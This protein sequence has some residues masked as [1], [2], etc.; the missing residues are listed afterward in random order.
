MNITRKIVSLMSFWLCTQVAFAQTVELSEG[1][2]CQ[3]SEVVGQD[4][5]ALSSGRA[6]SAKWYPTSVPTTVMGALTAN[7]EYQ[8]ILEKDN[9]RQYDKQRFLVPWLFKKSFRLDGLNDN[10]HVRLLFEGLDYRADI[11]LNGV[12][13]ASRDTIAGP[14]RT[15]AIDVTGV[16][17]EQN[18]LVVETWRCQPG[19]YNIGFVDWNPRPLDE[20]MGIVRPVKV[21][22]C[23]PVVIESPR[24]CTRLNL[25]TLKEAWVNVETQV[26]N[27]SNRDVTGKLVCS[28]EGEECDVPVTLKAK[29]TKTVRIDDEVMETLHVMNP[30]LWWCYTMGSPTLYSMNLSFEQNDVLSDNQEVSFGIREV[31]SFI[32]S[33]G[34]RAFT[35]N[36]K[37]IQLL[38]AGWTDDI[39]L[40][41][42]ADSYDRQLEMV[43]QMNLNTVRLEGFWGTSQALYDLCDEK[44]IL[45]L[46]GWSC[47]WEWED[48]LGK[49]C[50]DRY[51]G[52][53]TDD[54]VEIISRS[55]DDQLRYL[56]NHPSIIAW[57]VGSDKLPVPK[58]EQHYQEAQKTIDD[59]PY[60]TSAKQMESDI[61]GAS[62]TKMAGPYEYVAPAYWYRSEAPGGAFGFNTETG[63]GAQLPVKESLR[64]MLGDKLWPLDKVWD[65][66][67]TSAAEA[68]NKLDIL[69]KTVA[70]RY[71]EATGLDDFLRKAN[72]VNYDGTKAMF[73]AFRY[74][75]PKATALVQWML[76][77]ARPSVYWQLYDYYLR[78]NASFYAVRKACEP[79]QLIYNHYQHDV[80]AVNSLDDTII[81]TA[82]MN[83][84]GMDGKLLLSQ[85]KQVTMPPLSSVAVFDAIEL[86]EDN[87]YLFLTLESDGHI[88]SEN[89]YALTRSE[90]VFDWPKS[91][92][93]G[94]PVIRHADMKAIGNQLHPKC[95]VK[96][97][98]ENGEY[99]NLT[100]SNPSDQVAYMQRVVLKDKKGNP[101]DGVIYSDNYITIEPHGQKNIVC[102]LPKVM[103]YKVEIL[104]N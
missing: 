66:H 26:R 7:G 63:I 103:K 44:G 22:R 10:E 14:F 57:F 73:E 23:G 89:E 4:G 102:I 90:D 9:Y 81:A 101:I 42:N 51:G 13:V 24:V 47:F 32:T 94:T 52:I 98:E 20:S 55:Y 61:S 56:R 29:Q 17:K 6:S 95:Q 104:G 30:R 27:L 12:K 72:M 82:R 16:A 84:Y 53:L 79:V 40:R 83:V 64:Q 76:N 71:G 62:G 68:F 38:G 2:E 39:F 67:C 37:R 87:G 34:Y 46:A 21:Q 75:F 1:W 35:L 78:P 8:G 33:D 99:V 96:V 86:A 5:A 50:D 80:R 43:K 18:T 3:S 48:Y 60:I 59:R 69:K 97:T 11:Y 41:D 28:F 92:W 93:T 88:I 19:E 49:P 58:L 91:D 77:S 31:G 25:N 36:G 54:D 15:F 45:L 70:E 74:N 65:Y 100:V 85:V